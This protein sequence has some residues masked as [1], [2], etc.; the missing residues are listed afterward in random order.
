[1]SQSTITKNIQYTISAVAGLLLLLST[2]AITAETQT[3]SQ[4]LSISYASSDTKNIDV[5]TQL[6]LAKPEG[7]T[8]F[9]KQGYRSETAS[10]E[11]LQ[12][13]ASYSSRFDFSIYNVTTELLSDLDY[14]GFYHHFSITIDADTVF[15]NAYVYAKLYL[16]YEGG[17][18]N[19]YASSA[20]YPI[21]ADSSFDSFVINTV[22]EDG[23]DAGYYDIR[24]DLFDAEF[25]TRVVSYGP[26]D[27]YS[28]NALPL[29]DSFND[30]GYDNSYPVSD[31][32]IIGSGTM[33]SG[34]WLM[35]LSLFIARKTQTRRCVK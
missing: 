24:I 29:E 22:L 27:N 20:S 9:V 31:T 25:N 16:S 11:K 26:Y 32:L 6:K 17:P 35:I 30:D 33:G 28:I 7:S 19:Y 21:Y 15:N 8:A 13:K 14:D 18:W 5:L 10:T 23:Y 34:I 4:S 12:T 3:A 1:M 2:T